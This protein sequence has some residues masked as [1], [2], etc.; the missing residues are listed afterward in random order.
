M[1][2]PLKK[3]LLV[4][5]LVLASFSVYRVSSAASQTYSENNWFCKDDAF[6]G[7]G[8]CTYRFYP[9]RYTAIDSP[10]TRH[11]YQYFQMS[12]SGHLDGHGGYGPAGGKGALSGCLSESSAM[13]D[14]SCWNWVDEDGN[15]RVGD[16]DANFLGGGSIGDDFR[17]A[18]KYAIFDFYVNDANWTNV[19]METTGRGVQIASFDASRTTVNVGD[20]FTVDWEN[21]WSYDNTLTATSGRISCDPSGGVN[22]Y[23]TATCTALSAGTGS[24]TIQAEGPTGNGYKTLTKSITITVNQPPPPDPFS[25]VVTDRYFHQSH[26]DFELD[27]TSSANAVSYEA[28]ERRWTTGSWNSIG[29]TSSAITNLRSH[30]QAWTDMYFYVRAT[31]PYGTRETSVVYGGICPAPTV[32]LKGRPGTS[33][34]YS[35]GPITVAYNGTAQLNWTTSNATSCTA[36]GAWSGSKTASG[37]TQTLNNLTVSGTYTLTCAN[38]GGNTSP[39]SVTIN[40][41]APPAPTVD[42]KCDSA[43]TCGTVSYGGSKT[44]SWTVQGS[45]TSCIASNAWSG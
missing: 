3:I 8:T 33:G 31:N 21:D 22:N 41:S 12:F 44:L 34:S 20:T 1:N 6:S 16:G 37:G 28:F 14:G 9:D 27:W 42:L 35:N 2:D 43:D 10:Y 18:F 30:S 7:S 19:H 4:L 11:Y 45:V 17:P 13:W 38:Q 29:T 23:G 32:D 25:L 39:D 24:V 40:V 15:G 36:S 26:C 5:V